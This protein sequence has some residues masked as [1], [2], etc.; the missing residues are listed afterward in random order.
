MQFLTVMNE[1]EGLTDEEAQY[2]VHIEE[3]PVESCLLL[4]TP[5]E[6]DEHPFKIMLV[7]PADIKQMSSE[8]DV[9]EEDLHSDY[10]EK[11]PRCMLE[12]R[13]I[14]ELKEFIVHLTQTVTEVEQALTSFGKDS[15]SIVMEHRDIDE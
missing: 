13:S 11:E 3:G 2:D 5:E 9:R 7:D 12:F 15:S 10:L 14:L 6:A 4:Y 1:V 8:P